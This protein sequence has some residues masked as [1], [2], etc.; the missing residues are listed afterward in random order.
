MRVKLRVECIYLL[1]KTTLI[2]DCL[3]RC[4][5]A[6]LYDHKQGFNKIDIDCL[7]IP[8][9]FGYLLIVFFINSLIN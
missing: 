2:C 6:F 9:G 5:F 4:H 1:E 3:K 7:S 8:E